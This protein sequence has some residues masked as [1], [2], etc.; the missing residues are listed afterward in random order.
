LITLLRWHS[1]G[2]IEGVA[3]GEWV[4]AVVMSSGQ[5]VPEAAW[6]LEGCQGATVAVDSPGKFVAGDGVLRSVVRSKQEMKG[7]TWRLCVSDAGPGSARG[8]CP[9]ARAGQVDG[10]P[11]GD[12]L[13]VT[14]AQ[15]G[16]AT[17]P[18]WPE[19]VAWPGTVGLQRARVCC[20]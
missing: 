12:G 18:G 10:D 3:D 17:G 1:A 16:Q 14:V 20:R 4:A 19:G 15:L 11:E 8:S 9:Y 5:K 7:Q 13:V 6:A 2:Q